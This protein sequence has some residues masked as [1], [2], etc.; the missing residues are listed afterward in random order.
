MKKIGLYIEKLLAKHHYVVIPNLGGFVVQPQQAVILPEKIIPP[1]CCVSF[2]PLLSHSD[3][4][5]AVEMS[6]AEH[7]TYRQAT[8]YIENAVAVIK[9]ELKQNGISHIGNIGV[10]HKIKGGQLLF[11]PSAN[12][13]FL[14]ENLG[15]TEIYY[16]EKSGTNDLTASRT[17]VRPAGKTFRYAAAAALLVAVSWFSPNEH[18]DREANLRAD[19]LSLPCMFVTPENNSPQEQPC[20][21]EVVDEQDISIAV[22]HV[23]VA[24]LRTQKAAERFCDK[25]KESD[26]PEAHVLPPSKLYYKVAVAAFSEREEALE[27]AKTIRSR[28]SDFKEAWV[29]SE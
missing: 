24:G 28:S 21:E 25:L 20:P 17:P 22:H 29:F 4:L 13:S 3:G 27:Y 9:K 15:L 7:I 12:A 5:L 2:N 8:T 1:R 19:F 11:T 16:R 14:P 23:V 6:K 26:Y 18:L 10:L